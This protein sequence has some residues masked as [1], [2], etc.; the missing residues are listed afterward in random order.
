MSRK[1]DEYYVKIQDYAFVLRIGRVS[2]LYN[3]SFNNQY[4]SKET[5]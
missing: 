4:K 1:N 3:Q 5:R 2:E